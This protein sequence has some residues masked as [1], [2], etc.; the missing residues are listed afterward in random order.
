MVVRLAGRAGVKNVGLGLILL[1]DACGDDAAHA[2]LRFVV[3]YFG[4][5]EEY[6]SRARAPRL[7][8]IFYRSA[9]HCRRVWLF[10]ARL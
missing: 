4:M 10:C 3:E 9:A 5:T 7:A 8:S 6:P 2:I 1:S